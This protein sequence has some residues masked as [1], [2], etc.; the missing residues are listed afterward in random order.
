[1]MRLFIRHETRY[2]FDAPVPFGL[3]QL[4]LTPKSF[5]NQSVMDWQTRM[6]GGRKELHYHDHNRNLVE[7][8][9]FEPNI[10]TI[11]LISEGSVEIEDASGV[12]GAHE[13]AIPL[14]YFLQTSPRTKPGKGLRALLADLPDGP[15]LERLHDLSRLILTEVTYQIGA[16]EPDWSSEDALAAGKGVCQ[17]HTHI[18]VTA[19]RSLGIPARYV[20]GYL[21]I[22]E[23][24]VQ[25]A[26]H[27]WAEAYLD[28]LGW[29]G[30]DI[31]NGISPDNRYVRVATGLDYDQ[32]SPIKGNRL[33]SARDHLS[34]HVQ[35]TQQ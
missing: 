25:T 30:F 3:L 24:T 21:M 2:D 17:D 28:G 13:A 32:A 35:V 27:A 18:F 26:S 12:I 6:D 5:R 22:D 15:P 31:S 1:M 34:V 23:T 33:G 20:S 19:A 29:V 14:W 9:S 11:T 7:L 8:V 10:E 4:R 16:S